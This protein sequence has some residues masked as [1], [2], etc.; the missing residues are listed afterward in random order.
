MKKL[1]V[2]LLTEGLDGKNTHANPLKA[3]KGLSATEARKVPTPDINS[4]W[5]NLFHMVFWQDI[6]LKSIKGEKIDWEGIK[7]KDWLSPDAMKNDADW[8][9]LIMAFKKGLE[10]YKK[11]LA[12][13]DLTALIPAWNNEPVLKGILV[14]A[15]HNSYHIGQIV[16]ARQ[17]LGKWPPPDE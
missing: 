9:T 11:L 3:L 2:E 14:T 16:M 6:T 10:E 17:L 13:G 5:N 4:I 12:T 1:I 15:Q 7:G 8:D